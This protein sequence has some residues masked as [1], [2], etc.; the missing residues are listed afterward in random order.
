MPPFFF[1]ALLGHELLSA[2]SL[3]LNIQDNRTH[4]FSET[5]SELR[6]EARRNAMLMGIANEGNQQRLVIDDAL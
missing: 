6:R 3:P 2:Y 1:A 5:L 4:P